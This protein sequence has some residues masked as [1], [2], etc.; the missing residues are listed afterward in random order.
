[1]REMTWWLLDIQVVL[2]VEGQEPT[3]GGQTSTKVRKELELVK[4]QNVKLNFFIIGKD[5]FLKIKASVMPKKWLIMLVW[6]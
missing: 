3:Q 5:D 1:M 4:L 6:A 2:P